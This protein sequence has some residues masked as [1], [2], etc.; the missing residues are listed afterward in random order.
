MTTSIY[1]DLIDLEDEAVP[2]TLNG[3]GL[4]WRE[5]NA[6]YIAAFKNGKNAAVIVESGAARYP[7]ADE[8][9]T[10]ALKTLKDSITRLGTLFDQS[11][12]ALPVI[13]DE[14]PELGEK[15]L[16]DML[17]WKSSSNQA[18]DFQ[19]IWDAVTPV[20]SEVEKQNAYLAEAMR[21]R[22]YE[23]DPRAEHGKNVAPGFEVMR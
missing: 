8:A 3:R 19:R 12:R 20:L 16:S 14:L 2:V 6:A 17:D 18:S 11:V 23:S 10:T 13:L 1:S 21:Y 22:L 4:T 15:M 5:T 7:A 9:Y